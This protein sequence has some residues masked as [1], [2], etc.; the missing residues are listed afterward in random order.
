METYRSFSRKL[1][2]VSTCIKTH[3]EYNLTQRRDYQGTM[4]L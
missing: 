3:V 4:L 2:T 1:T